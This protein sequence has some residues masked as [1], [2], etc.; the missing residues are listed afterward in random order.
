MSR[1]SILTDV[2]RHVWTADVLHAELPDDTE[3]IQ[4]DE[5]PGFLLYSWSPARYRGPIGGGKL[6]PAGILPDVITACAPRDYAG[7][8]TNAESVVRELDEVIM[9]AVDLH[10]FRCTWAWAG[11]LPAWA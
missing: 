7:R 1:P 8:I 4:F 9:E 5:R 3:V 6:R 11:M 2:A 10:W